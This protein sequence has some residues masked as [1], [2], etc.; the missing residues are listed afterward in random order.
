MLFRSKKEKLYTKKEFFERFNIDLNNPTI[1]TT[2]HPETVGFEKNIQYIKELIAAL[3]VLAKK[4]QIVITM[5]NADTEGLMIR[6]QIEAFG[7]KHKTVFLVESFG[8][9]GYLSCMKYSKMLLGNTSSAFVE[10]A[11]FPKWV[12][13]LGHRQDGRINTPNIFTIPVEKERILKTVKKIESL[14]ETPPESNVYGN[15]NAA[16]KIIRTI[17]KF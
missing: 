9:K 1:L 4:Y 8:M 3:N 6:R 2:F 17:K 7:Q 14:P 5:P 12:I 15:G 11:F 13:N 10:A 16:E